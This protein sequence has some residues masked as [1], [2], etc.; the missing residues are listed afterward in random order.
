MQNK[1]NH[2]DLPKPVKQGLYDP[3]FEHDAC[4]VGMVA[5]IEGIKS[6]EI[7]DQGLEALCN[8]GH[9]GATGADPETGDGAGILVQMPHEFF[10]LELE[11]MGS[12]LPDIGDYGVGMAFL[13]SEN[14]EFEKCMKT[15]QSCVESEGM[16]LLTWRE[17][18]IDPSKIGV[19]A[20]A[21]R[22]LITQFFVAP[23][24]SL[25]NED[26]EFAL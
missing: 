3:S 15:I 23:N 17:V 12:I 1:Y 11:H 18:P 5:N 6:H 19:L 8:L 26:F 4:G 16:S 13:P 21:S 25:A 9:R 22:P 20:N 7:V 24:S 14:K 10:A 2:P